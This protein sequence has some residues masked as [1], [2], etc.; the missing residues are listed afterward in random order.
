MIYLTSLNIYYFTTKKLTL[1]VSKLF[2]NL[3]DTVPDLLC[4]KQCRQTHQNA[5]FS[6][7]RS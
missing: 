4:Q 5:F 1:F 7:K 3:K 6:D 2:R